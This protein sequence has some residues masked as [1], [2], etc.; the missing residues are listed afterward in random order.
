MFQMARKLILLSYDN[1]RIF[2]HAQEVKGMW[3]FMKKNIHKILLNLLR[4]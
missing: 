3:F 1:M 4:K 2:S